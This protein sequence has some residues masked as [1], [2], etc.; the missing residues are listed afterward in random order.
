MKHVLPAYRWIT[1][2][3]IQQSRVTPGELHF[4]RGETLLESNTLATDRIAIRGFYP[5]EHSLKVVFPVSIR[6]PQLFFEANG[7][8]VKGTELGIALLWHSRESG[9]RG[10]SAVSCFG[11]DDPGPV[12][13]SLEVCF[14]SGFLRGELFLTPVLLVAEALHEGEPAPAGYCNEAGGLLGDL[15]GT[16]RICIDGNG[17]QFPITEFN[18]NDAG[19]PLWTLHFE[20]DDPLTD[21]FSTETVEI[22]IN[23]AHRDYPLLVA[24]TPQTIPPMMKEILAAALTGLIYKLRDDPQSWESI[25]NGDSEPGT[26]GNAVWYFINK[27]HWSVN[28]PEDLIACVQKS[29]GN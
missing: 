6:N 15:C 4:Y 7:V 14:E 20:W 11:S 17:S 12:S 24:D 3:L 13:V 10:V 9:T 5:D 29:L 16:Y 23:T 8:A 22:R 27:L 18:S 28:S 21:V 2:E 1:S 25:L 26:V 19:A